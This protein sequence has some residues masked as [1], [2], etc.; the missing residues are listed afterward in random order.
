MKILKPIL[1]IMSAGII[2]FMHCTNP[3][4]PNILTITAADNGKTFAFVRNADFNVTFNEC[5][6]CAYSWK[7][8]KIDSTIIMY[9]GEKYSDPSCTN[10]VGGS[11]DV[12]FSFFTVDYGSSDMV[13]SYFA[14]TVRL[15]IEV[16]ALD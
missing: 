12:T 6:G 3:A 10:C 15:T 13:F 7:I 11:H 8:E 2:I 16:T 5:G 4:K 14:D 1:L 9:K